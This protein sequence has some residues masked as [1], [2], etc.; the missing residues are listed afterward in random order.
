MKLAIPT[1]DRKTIAKRTGRCKEFVIVE[2][3]N[4]KIQYNYV[5]N[6]LEHNHDENEEHEH[7]HD[8]IIKLLEG[9]DLLVVKNVGKYM[10]N[11]LKK[12]HIEFIRTSDTKIVDIISNH[13]NTA[14]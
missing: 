10:L 9:I 5:A 2:I 11:D 6:T 8:E 12:H 13:K 3:D 7:S 14:R 4:N 1:N